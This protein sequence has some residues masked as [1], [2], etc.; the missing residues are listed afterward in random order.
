MSKKLHILYVPGL[1]D[2]RISGQRLAVRIWRIWGV[3]AEVLQMNWADKESW[4]QK[5][6]RLLNRID[7]LLQSGEPLALVGTSAGG[8]AVINAYAAR[9]SRLV[10]CVLI[11]GKVNHPE[12]LGDWHRRN[13]P[14]FVDSANECAEALQTLDTPDRRRIQSRYAIRD[15]IVPKQDS[16]VNGAHNK[17]VPSIGHIYTIATQITF[18]APLFLR[19]LKR[20]SGK[21]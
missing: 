12:T 13:V 20:L 17:T 4:Q 9:K 19:F 18:G 16:H 15:G 3:H 10:G 1:G 8:S 2:S 5:R 21:K 6:D 11:C 14:A 7:E